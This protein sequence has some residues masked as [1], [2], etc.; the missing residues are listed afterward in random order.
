MVLWLTL[1][2]TQRATLTQNMTPHT[3]P[4][5]TDGSSAQPDLSQQARPK[6]HLSMVSMEFQESTSLLQV[7]SQTMLCRQTLFS[8][9]CMSWSVASSVSNSSPKSWTIPGACCRRL[10]CLELFPLCLVSTYRPFQESGWPTQ[11][12]SCWALCWPSWGSSALSPPPSWWSGR[13]L[14]T[15]GTTSS[16]PRPCIKD[17]GRPVFRRAP[18]K[19]NA[20]CLTH[21]CKYQVQLH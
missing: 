7:H 15:W 4:L 16:P 5:I 2:L 17:C 13:L 12:C 6:T 19:S 18:G 3:I 8:I 1:P 14:P 10:L 21:F 20:K 9:H 11:G